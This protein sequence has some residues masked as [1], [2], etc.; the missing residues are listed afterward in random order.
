MRI[1]CLLDF[2]INKTDRWLWD[3]LPG[4]KDEVEFLCTSAN[5]RFSGWGK[6]I[7]YYPKFLINAV[8]AVRATH[9][10]KYD[11]IVG[12]EGKNSFSLGLIRSVLKIDDPKFLALTFSIRG[13]LKSYLNFQKLGIQGISHA[14]VPTMHEWRKYK[15]VGL[16]E[17]RCSYCPIGVHDPFGGMNTAPILEY[18]FSGGRSG[19]DY[20]TLMEAVKDLNIKFIVNA[21]EFN[22]RGIRVTENVQVNNLLPAKEYHNLHWG[23]RF[24]V[25]P[26]HEVDEAVGLTEILNAMAA[27][28][29]VIATRVHGVEDYV[30]DGRTGLLIPPSNACALRDAIKYLWENQSLREQM[31]INARKLFEEKYTFNAF[32]Q[33]V[34]EII[35]KMVN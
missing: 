14:T 4:N 30:D 23:A 25:V 3:Y 29:A 18:V 17:N 6:I 19:R 8:R 11:L 5:D 32:A 31:G 28:K 20:G 15:Q 22:L 33:R 34:N 2:P 10:K 7:N 24:V 12:W 13:P 35:Q 16:T 1:L 27:G 21:R 9:K 26:L